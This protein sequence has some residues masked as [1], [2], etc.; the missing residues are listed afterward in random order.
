MRSCAAASARDAAPGAALSSHL[1]AAIA[2]TDRP[3]M[4]A[5]MMTPT[6]WYT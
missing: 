6:W 4:N 1:E 2:P 3:I 5:P